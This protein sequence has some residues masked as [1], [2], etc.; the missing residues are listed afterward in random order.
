MV[1]PATLVFGKRK[2]K[3]LPRVEMVWGAGLTAG[4]SGN[5]MEELVHDA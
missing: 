1:K 5:E 2:F 4:F 3:T